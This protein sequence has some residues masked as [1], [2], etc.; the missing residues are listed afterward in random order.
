MT[1][2]PRDH[3]TQQTNDPIIMIN[4]DRILTI[5]SSDPRAA[6]NKQGRPSKRCARYYVLEATIFVRRFI[7]VLLAA[8]TVNY[9]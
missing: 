8:V 9:N 3:A 5:H 2:R 7:Y 6:H 4:I 1:S